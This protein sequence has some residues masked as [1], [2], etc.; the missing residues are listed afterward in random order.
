MNLIDKIQNWGDHHHPKWIDYLRILL[1]L[2]LIWKGVSFYTNMHAFSLLMKG[3]I[4]GKAVS[5]SMLAH[6]IIIV[7]II[8][9]AAIVL[10]TYTRTFC[11][12]NIPILIGAI[13]FVDTSAGIFRPYTDFWIA[14]PV[15]AALIFFCVEGNGIISIEHEE[16]KKKKSRWRR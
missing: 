13:V 6:F 4:L 9:G 1:G 11:L 8:G 3:G 2:V 10:G 16:P 5:I 15:L 7:H 12:I 14:L